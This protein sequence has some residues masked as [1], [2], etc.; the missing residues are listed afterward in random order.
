MGKRVELGN[1]CVRSKCYKKWLSQIS[2]WQKHLRKTEETPSFQ[3]P[4]EETRR[5]ERNELQNADETS[6]CDSSPKG[7]RLAV[8]ESYNIAG[9]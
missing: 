4:F 9:P 3:A 5:G 6:S 2:A 1:P 8:D 7:S